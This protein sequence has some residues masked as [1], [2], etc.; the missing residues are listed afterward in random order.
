MTSLSRRAKGPV[1]PTDPRSE[2]ME[3]PVT[4]IRRSPSSYTVREAG[5]A[6]S[7]SIHTIRSWIARRRIA[8]VRLGRCI[9]VPVSEVERLLADG[10]VPAR[11]A[12][13][14]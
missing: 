9:R 14:T 1:T 3:S 6:L 5:I 13:R 8:Y 2:G 11:P 12:K 7:V 10:L 4:Q